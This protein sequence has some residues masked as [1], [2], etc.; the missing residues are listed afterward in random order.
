VDCVKLL[1]ERGA[2]PNAIDFDYKTALDWATIALHSADAA[3]RDALTEIIRTLTLQTYQTRPIWKSTDGGDGLGTFPVESLLAV[4]RPHFVAPLRVVR[5]S[6][7]ILETGESGLYHL[8]NSMLFSG[9]WRNE[10]K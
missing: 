1:V 3:N 7:A 2:D 8:L 9:D 6:T 5:P 10:R 4:P